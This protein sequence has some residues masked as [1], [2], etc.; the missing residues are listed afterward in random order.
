MVFWSDIIAGKRVIQSSRILIQGKFGYVESLDN[1]KEEICPG[2]NLRALFVVPLP[3]TIGQL[4]V[5]E[6]PTSRG[7]L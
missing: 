2:G 4:V 3:T 7:Y 6:Q 5:G 1:F